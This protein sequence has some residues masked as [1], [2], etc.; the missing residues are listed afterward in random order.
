MADESSPLCVF[1]ERRPASFV[2]ARRG[3]ESFAGVCQG[4]RLSLAELVELFGTDLRTWVVFP[5]EFTYPSVLTLEEEERAAVR[6]AEA[7]LHEAQRG[8]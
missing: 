3:V 5:A 4:C 7:L 2:L 8:R 1:C 6:A